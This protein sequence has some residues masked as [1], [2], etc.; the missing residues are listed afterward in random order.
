MRSNALLNIELE[1]QAWLP[2]LGSCEHDFTNCIGEYIDFSKGWAQGLGE[3]DKLN[4][5]IRAGEGCGTAPPHLA[6][7][8]KY[9][10]S[11]QQ[12]HRPG[13]G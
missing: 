5:I 4:A 12:R 7:N 3:P 10:K 11:P 13:V 6:H 9:R 1:R 8:A 2:S